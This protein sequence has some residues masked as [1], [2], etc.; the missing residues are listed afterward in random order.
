MGFRLPSASW[1]LMPETPMDKDDLAQ[2]WEGHVR[3]PGKIAR[4]KPIPES[5][6][7]HHA[8]DS[9]LRTGIYAFDA[10]HPFTSLLLGEVI[11]ETGES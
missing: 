1:V 4:V 6:A 5:H 8:A 3:N 10:G 11:H 7:M 2:P 9:H